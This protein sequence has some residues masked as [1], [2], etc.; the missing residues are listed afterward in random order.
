[1]LNQGQV[2]NSLLSTR[3]LT[4]EKVELIFSTASEFQEVNKRSIK[5]VPTLRGRTVLNLFFEPST[6]TR[7]SFEVAAKR[8]SADTTNFSA[9]GSSV[10]K[11][12]TLFDTLRTLNAMN[13]DCVVV[14]HPHAGS[15]RFV[16]KVLPEVSVINAGDG[17]GEHPTQ[18][19]LDVF[20][21]KQNLG[22][23]S[24]LKILFVGDI[25]RSRVFKSH[26]FL[27]KTLGNEVRVCGPCTLLP[28]LGDVKRF[29]ELSAALEGVDV[30]VSLRVKEEYLGESLIPSKDFFMRNYCITEELL[31]KHCPDSLFI[32]PGPFM[33]DYE[34]SS[35]VLQSS[36]SLYEQQVEAGVSTRMA[37]MYLL[38]TGEKK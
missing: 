38:M 10:S 20:T 4:K 26:Y 15:A 21:L 30:V 6:R 29:S 12:E 19:L 18:A 17:M 3:E 36:R 11:G 33:R 13:V 22:R 31:Q 14:R 35:E 7:T 27:H 34:V 1:M 9:S 25:L 16:E 32:S 5:K 24:G 2:P 37:L 23:T 28:N 8:L